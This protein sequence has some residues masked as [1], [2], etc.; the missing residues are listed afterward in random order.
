[1]NSTAHPPIVAA[2]AAWLA[3]EIERTDYGE[4][5]ATVRLHKGREA[6]IDFSRTHKVKM[7]D[8]HTGTTGG[9]DDTRRR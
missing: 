1:M 2:V 6:I 4:L 3:E 8:P 9:T 5:H 7:T